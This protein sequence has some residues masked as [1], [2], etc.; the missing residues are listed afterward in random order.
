MQ[1]VNSVQFNRI[2]RNKIQFHVF[3][4]LYN[5]STQSEYMCSQRNHCVSQYLRATQI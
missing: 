4:S 2:V 3:Y 1:A 5:N